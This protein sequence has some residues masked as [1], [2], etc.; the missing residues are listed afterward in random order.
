[1]ST[2]KQIVLLAACALVLATQL[3]SVLASEARTRVFLNGHPIAVF[4]S[5]GDSF[6][7]LE[8]PYTG[9]NSRL[10][11]FNTLESYGATHSWGSWNAFELWLIAKKAT[12]NGRRGVWHCTT[13]GSHDTYGRVLVDC[14]DLIVSQVRQGF[15]HAMNI[16]DTPSSMYILRAQQDAIRHHRGMWAHGVPAFIITSLHSAAED[17]GRAHNYNRLVST[18]D[19]HTEKWEH[20]DVYHECQ[21]V[22]S[23]EIRSDAQ[24]VYEF[25]RDLRARPGLGEVLADVPNLLLVELVD[26]YARLGALPEYTTPEVR[27]AVEPILAQAKASGELGQ[28]RSV[29]GS[30]MVY[31]AFD[32]RYGP[33]RAECFRGRNW[34]P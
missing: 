18:R 25:A 9:A 19:G 17:P 6:R 22:C 30:C 13:D 3:S 27:A 14:P 23:T 24:R 20:H 16:D 1:M 28:T 29:Q 2:S 11:G 21:R 10:A 34:Q 31:A 15:A 12:Y 26:R 8:G 7:M 32:R 5:D 33:N 4:F